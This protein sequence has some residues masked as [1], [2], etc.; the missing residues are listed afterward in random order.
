ME[1]LSNIK[2]EFSHMRK[3]KHPNIISTHE[4]YIDPINYQI[5][6]VME[7]FVGREMF[8]VLEMNGGY[9]EE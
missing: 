9:T 7:L 4:L 8:E 6:I 3:L 1:A 5:F 2:Y